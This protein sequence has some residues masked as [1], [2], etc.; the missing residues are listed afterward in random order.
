MKFVVDAQLPRRLAA[1]LAALGEDAI[2]TLDLPQGNR[3]PDTAIID[4]AVREN[5]VVVTKDSDF[6][7]HLLLRNDSFKLLFITTGNI[8]NE[9]L[10]SLIRSHWRQLQSM[11]SQGRYVELSRTTLILHF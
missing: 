3:T 6:V 11:L 2:H 7:D 8:P 9:S 4:L 5:R 1:E 10:V